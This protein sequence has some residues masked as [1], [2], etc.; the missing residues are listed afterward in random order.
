MNNAVITT[1]K[2]ELRG[3]V[4]DKKSLTMMLLMPVIIPIFIFL[5]SFVY[6]KMMNP[7][8][9]DKYV[10]GIN[11]NMSDVELE[12]IKEMD[13]ETK[14][15]ATKDEMQTAFEAGEVNAY[16]I[17]TNNNYLIYAND[18]GQDSYYASIS[19][20]N[21]LNAYNT[22]LAQD[23]L[24]SIDADIDRIY[25]N[26]S[27]DFEELQGSNDLVNE[28]ITMGFIFAIMAISLTAIYSATDSTAG[29]K[30]RGTLETILTF[31][32]KSEELITGKFLAIFI[33]CLVTAV[34]STLLA[35]VSF[36]VSSKIFDIYK[37]TVLN[38]N[39]FTITMGLL[40]MIT[41]SVFVSG[42]CIA[43]ASL[44]KSYKE[45]Q[46]A[47]TPISLVTMIP[48]FFDILKI[49]MTPV[50][51]LVPVV[52]HTMLLKT[53]FCGTVQ[54]ADLINLVFMF[55]STIVYSVIIIKLITKQY[56]SEKV[57]FSI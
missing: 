28:I 49:D 52:N 19:F 23:Y 29:E 50:L 54:S 9:N 55:V 30:E 40:I 27:Y 38:F 3:I 5:F 4:R 16:A 33:S 17:K 13:F 12:I 53:V 31:P 18:K 35:V 42:V 22:Y 41:F 36:G 46:S 48:M 25:N 47:L 57:L 7:D 26:L 51:A 24:A 15:Y 56:K 20:S 37:D 44:A 8:D 39:F 43:I 11:Y 10:V 45:A 32:I 21:Y 14:Y 1:V 6:D 2:K 34:I